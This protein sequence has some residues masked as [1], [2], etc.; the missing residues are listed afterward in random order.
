MTML[1]DS[2]RDLWLTGLPPGSRVTDVAAPRHNR[3]ATL[4]LVCALPWPI[5][6]LG[7]IL[8]EQVGI[9]PHYPDWGLA[10]IGP[11]LFATPI[12]SIIAGAI[13]V[14]RSLRVPA[15]RASW[16]RAVIGWVLGCLWLFATFL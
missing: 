13:G 11:V 16:W 3:A 6:L 10:F 15:L 5:Y 7:A 12:V 9:R 14:Y 4:S 8:L 2:D 1:P